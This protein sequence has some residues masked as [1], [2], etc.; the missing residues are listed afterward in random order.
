M[1]KQAEGERIIIILEYGISSNKEIYRNLCKKDETI[2]IFI[3]LVVNAVWVRTIGMYYCP[4][5]RKICGRQFMFL[6]KE[7]W[8][9]VY[10]HNIFTE[11]GLWLIIRRICLM[12]KT[13]FEKETCFD[14]I[15]HWKNKQKQI[16]FL[17]SAGF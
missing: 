10:H 16:A 8:D 4:M 11:S 1:G 13:F 12:K 3:Q 5:Q 9:E 7:N 2:Q 14:L 17:L 6:Y 15:K